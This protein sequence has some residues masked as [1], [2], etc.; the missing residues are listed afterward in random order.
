MSHLLCPV[1]VVAN[2]CIPEAAHFPVYQIPFQ[3]LQDIHCSM[4]LLFFPYYFLPISHPN[5]SLKIP[6][7]FL[8]NF[9]LS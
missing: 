7:S 2:I 5:L 6:S 1:H 9:Y 3:Y 4:V 8:M